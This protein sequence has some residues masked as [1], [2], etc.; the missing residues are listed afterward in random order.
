MTRYYLNTEF[1]DD[2]SI[3]DLISIGIECEDG[4][5]YYAQS[6]E[7]DHR[8]ASVWVKDNVLSLLQTCSHA[9]VTH[10]IQGLYRADRAYHRRQ[11][12]QCFDPQRVPIHNCPWRSREHIREEVKVFLDPARY[13]K[14]DIYGWCSAY[15]FVALCQLFGTM[16]ALPEGYPHYI[17]DLQQVLDERGIED[18]ELPPQEGGVHNALSDARHIKRLWEIYG[19]H[20]RNITPS[21]FGQEYYGDFRE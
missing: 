5:E 11:D 1:I 12:G 10:G 16:M 21:Q 9:D 2:G 8:K 7:F 4:R 6:C 15:D 17:R 13:G 14:P 20:T 19:G 18:S 3:I